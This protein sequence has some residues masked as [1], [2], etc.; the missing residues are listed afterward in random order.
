MFEKIGEGTY[1]CV[2]R[3]SLKC[4][5]KKKVD[6]NNTVSKIMLKDDAAKEMREFMLV[7][8]F[9]KDNEYHLGTPVECAPDL[10]SQEQLEAVEKCSIGKEIGENPDKYRLLVLKN[11]GYDLDKFFSKIT[12]LWKSLKT[13]R[14]LRA[15]AEHFWVAVHKLFRG[16]DFFHRKGIVHFDLK[17]QNI[18]YN[19]DTHDMNFIDFGL[20]DSK[21]NILR[22]ARRS[23]LGSLFH[24]SY[25]LDCGFLEEDNFRY[26]KKV[27]P[28]IRLSIGNHL[29]DMIL[30]GQKD[31]GYIYRDMRHPSAYEIFFAYISPDQ[32]AHDSEI[33]MYVSTFTN[34]MNQVADRVS[35]EEFADQAVDFIDIFG[36]GFS[37]QYALDT[38]RMKFPGSMSE[39]FYNDATALFKTMYTADMGAR[40]YSTAVLLEN[41]EALLRKHGFHADKKTTTMTT[42]NRNITINK[43]RRGS[44]ISEA[45]RS[46]AHEDPPHAK[47][48]RKKGGSKTRRRQKR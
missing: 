39:D 23:Q 15:E 34:W 2:H 1:G 10:A 29:A 5:G 16:L 26:F 35:Y 38:M 42:R 21:P 32:K 33:N 44:P 36:L 11:G 45:M 41:Y 19:M 18:V 20:M 17:P 47:N 3:P 48:K 40:E 43:T 9:D 30:T 24:W 28:I 14:A 46:F 25:P 22:Q 6:Y 27:G 12:E 8:R 4:K 7:S 13:K 31:D 37:L